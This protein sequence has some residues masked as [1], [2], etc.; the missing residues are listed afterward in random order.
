[1]STISDALAVA[2]AVAALKLKGARLVGTSEGVEIHQ[3]GKPI[4][5]LTPWAARRFAQERAEAEAQ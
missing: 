1:M 2:S 3:P 5:L 4:L